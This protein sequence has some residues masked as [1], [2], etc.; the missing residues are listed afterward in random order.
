MNNEGDDD[1]QSHAQVGGTMQKIEDGYWFRAAGY[2][3][4]ACEKSKRGISNRGGE[5][6]GGYQ[7]GKTAAGVS[8]D[9]RST[10]NIFLWHRAG[11][12]PGLGR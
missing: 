12:Q 7:R 6:C 9:D 8:I 4:T 1:R 2:A 10:G 3:Q 11:W 5:K